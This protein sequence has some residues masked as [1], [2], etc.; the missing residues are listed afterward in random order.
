[1]YKYQLQSIIIKDINE[2]KENNVILLTLKFL[3]L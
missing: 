2:N 1:M 3:F